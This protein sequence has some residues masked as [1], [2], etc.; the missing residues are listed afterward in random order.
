MLISSPVKERAVVDIRATAAAHRDIVADLLAI[1]GLSGADTI[2]SLYG[3]GK[4][5]VLKVS[6]DYVWLGG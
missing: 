5:T 6:K 3:I 2:A 4:G 1:F